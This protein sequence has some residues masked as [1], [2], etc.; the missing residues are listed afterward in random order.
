[1]SPDPDRG[2]SEFLLLSRICRNA[3]SHVGQLDGA[4]YDGGRPIPPWLATC[5]PALIEAGEVTLGEP[6]GESCGLRRVTISA[7]GRARYEQLCVDVGFTLTRRVRRD[8]RRHH[9][10]AEG[11][12]PALPEAGPPTHTDLLED[13]ESPGQYWLHTYPMNPVV[14]DGIITAWQCD[15]C[16][17]EQASSPRPITPITP[18][19]ETTPRPGFD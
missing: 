14:I 3:P 13:D 10:A 4:F 17:Y 19:H 2:I 1:M 15:G 7:E 5:A 6:E 8:R 18:P 9:A 11:R 12:P 16:G